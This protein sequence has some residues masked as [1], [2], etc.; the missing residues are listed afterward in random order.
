MRREF[1]FHSLLQDLRDS[2]QQ[3]THETTVSDRFTGTGGLLA[4]HGPAAGSI[5]VQIRAPVQVHASPV[6]VWTDGRAGDQPD[7][8]ENQ[9][10]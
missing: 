3:K 8:H 4:A 1:Q 5:P 10:M 2:K 6:Y 7:C 9:S